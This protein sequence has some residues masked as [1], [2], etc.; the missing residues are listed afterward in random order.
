MLYLNFQIVSRK[1]EVVRIF[2]FKR[3]TNTT[4]CQQIVSLCWRGVWCVI[5]G[6]A[7]NRKKARTTGSCHHHC[8]GVHV[9][10]GS[11]SWPLLIRAT[12]MTVSFFMFGVFG[13]CV[14]VGEG[15]EEEKRPFGESSCLCAVCLCG[16]GLCAVLCVCCAV[17]V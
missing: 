11:C 16:C 4:I 10:W 14:C 3:T 2:I 15:R 9:L 12:T 6:F 8:T 17:C 7:R 13:V 1:A 5:I